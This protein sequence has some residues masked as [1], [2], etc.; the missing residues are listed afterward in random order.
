MLI[1][2]T[3]FLNYYNQL[4]CVSKLHNFITF[5]PRT[6]GE[7]QFKPQRKTPTSPIYTTLT[8]ASTPRYGPHLPNATSFGSP[9]TYAIAT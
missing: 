1:L 7:I 5:V 6:L 3:N 8:A 2:A 4:T 9:Q